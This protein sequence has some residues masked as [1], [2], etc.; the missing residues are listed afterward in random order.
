LVRE[1]H[2]T[3]AGL[4]GGLVGCVVFLGGCYTPNQNRL[5]E[6]AQQLVQ[7]GM[8]MS[9]AQ[10]QLQAVHFTCRPTGSE[11]T[12]CYRYRARLLFSRCVERIELT[13]GNPASEVV[14]NVATPPL[15]CDSI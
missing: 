2:T 1:Q 12:T 6:E 14:T 9:A 4:A 7:S 10:K 13:E 8:S 11:V 3:K 15:L 5:A